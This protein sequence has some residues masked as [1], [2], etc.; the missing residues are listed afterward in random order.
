MRGVIIIKSMLT[1]FLPILG[2]KMNYFS[3]VIVGLQG[4]INQK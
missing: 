3:E 4:W 1:S 2:M